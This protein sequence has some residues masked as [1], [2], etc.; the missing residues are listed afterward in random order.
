MGRVWGG[1]ESEFGRFGNIESEKDV[2]WYKNGA[3]SAT[4][5]RKTGDSV[6]PVNWAP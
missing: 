3:K 4:K 2:K 1:L 5:R 6:F